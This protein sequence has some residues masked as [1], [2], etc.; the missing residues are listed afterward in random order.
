MTGYRLATNGLSDVRS[1]VSVETSLDWVL[2]VGAF[3]CFVGHGA[4]GIMTK[5]AWLPLF[6]V[7]GIGPVLAYKLMPVIGT[8]DILLGTLAL[9]RPRAALVAYMTLWAIWTAALRPLSGLPVWEML[10]RGGNYG[11]PF[12]LLLSSE[13]SRAPRAWFR[14]L[15]PRTMTPELAGRLRIALS[16]TTALLLIGHGALSLQGKNEIVAHYALILPAAGSAAFALGW[17]EIAIAGLVLVRP[18]IGLCLFIALWKLATESLFIAAG[19]P[20]WEWIERGGSY[21]APLALALILLYSNKTKRPK[22]A[23]VT[24]GE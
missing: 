12:A 13:V 14:G 17:A 9:I 2:R 5:E 20:I 6:A 11:V 7:A 19:A 23:D 21:T 8:V 4:F 3:M 16:V 22:F 18:T 1:A 15:R 24:N 10:E